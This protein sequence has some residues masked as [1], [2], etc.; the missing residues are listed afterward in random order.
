MTYT[1]HLDIFIDC[2][3]RSERSIRYKV[4]GTAP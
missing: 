4:E 1:N 2:L 3:Q